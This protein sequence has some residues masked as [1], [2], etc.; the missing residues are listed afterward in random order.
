MKQ[1]TLETLTAL[2]ENGQTHGVDALHIANE[3]G[4]PEGDGHASIDEGHRFILCLQGRPTY[5]LMR[6]GESTHLQIQR[7]QAVFI[8][9]GTWIVNCSTEP[10]ASLGIIYH[11]TF[12]RFIS[13]EYDPTQCRAVNIT[14][15]SFYHHPA[16]LEP[17]QHLLFDALAGT[18]SRNPQGIY[19]IRL[20]EA[21]L[22]AT[23]ETLRSCRTRPDLALL[24]GGKA[25]STW[26]AAMQYVIEYCGQE[27]DRDVVARHLDIH[28]NHVSRL[29]TQ[30]SGMTFSRFL[31]R[32][33][34]ERARE[35]LRNPNVSI[36]QIAALS[37][38]SSIH[39][40]IRCFRECYN[41]TPGDV[42]NNPEP[43]KRSE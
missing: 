36:K 5:A 20:Y 43:P 34:L 6:D 14:P 40:F 18:S 33:R 9:A 3:T 16:V 17:S 15:S 23:L 7:R 28:P 42:R 35:L 19:V 2:L 26:R 30:Y 10:Y 12:T 41:R 37:G 38:F 25:F 13:V 21:I 11:K 27:L 8:R 22:A 4:F 39:Y 29:F 31:L 24:S 32:A 1:L